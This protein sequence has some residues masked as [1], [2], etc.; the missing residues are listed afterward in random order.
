MCWRCG[1]NSVSIVSGYP[2]HPYQKKAHSQE[3]GISVMLLLV[4]D[5]MKFGLAPP[6]VKEGNGPNDGYLTQRME[7]L[8]HDDESWKR[9]VEWL[10]SQ[11]HALLQCCWVFVFHY[12][13]HTEESMTSQMR[14]LGGSMANA[15]LILRHHFKAGAKLREK[16]YSSNESRNGKRPVVNVSHTGRHHYTSLPIKWTLGQCKV[17]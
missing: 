7:H 17:Q 14:F 15:M 16:C 6:L 12:C 8:C 10:H 1:S 4:G 3:A 13:K 9:T 2:S 11:A 5:P